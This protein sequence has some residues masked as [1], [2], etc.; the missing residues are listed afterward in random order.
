MVEGDDYISDSFFRERLKKN[1]PE[2][3]YGKV[4]ELLREYRA[5][6]HLCANSSIDHTP[7]AEVDEVWHEHILFT[8]DYERWCKL[9][10]KTIQHN[11]E[12]PWNKQDYKSMYKVTTDELSYVNKKSVEIPKPTPKPV[13]K[14]KI[15]KETKSPKI[16]SSPSPSY[17]SSPDDAFY[18]SSSCSSSSCSSS[19]CGGGGD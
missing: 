7:S 18:S 14:V 6:L 19:S 8:K 17:V 16:V 3:S 15:R 4:T 11:P 2:W 9:L 1:H 13:S 10:G 5:F 12:T